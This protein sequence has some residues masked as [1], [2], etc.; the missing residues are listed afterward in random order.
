MSAQW[1]ILRMFSHLVVYDSS[2]TQWQ[3]LVGLL[4]SISNILYNRTH[5]RS[6]WVWVTKDDSPKGGGNCIYICYASDVVFHDTTG[7]NTGHSWGKPHG[8]GTYA[9]TSGIFKQAVTPLKPCL[10]GWKAL[11]VPL[12]L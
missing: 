10:A 8:H 6:V 11:L 4:F 3:V 7:A 2:F 9:D 5:G 1:Q 12:L